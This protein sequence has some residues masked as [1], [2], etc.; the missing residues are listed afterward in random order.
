MMGTNLQEIRI[1]DSKVVVHNDPSK[2]KTIVI[3]NKVKDFDCM[4]DMLIICT[5]S[6]GVLASRADFD[7]L[8]PNLSFHSL[9]SMGSSLE[10][11]NF[12]SSIS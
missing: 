10:N 12:V 7:Y 1:K 4:D 8:T 2:N 9:T 6:G 3:R 5:V 11:Y